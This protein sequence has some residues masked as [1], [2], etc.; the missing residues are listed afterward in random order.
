MLRGSF[1]Q[2]NTKCGKD[3]C[4]CKEGTGHSH[5]SISGSEGG[6]VITRKVHSADIEWVKEFTKNYK[7][8]RVMRKKLPQIEVEIKKNIDAWEKKLVKEARCGKSYLEA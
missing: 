6:Q 7:E 2:I 4:W 5:A 8:F 3:N 1:C